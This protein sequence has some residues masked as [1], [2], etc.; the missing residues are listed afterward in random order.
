MKPF[1]T[2]AEESV[3]F[4][5]GKRAGRAARGRSG[6]GLVGRVRAGVVFANLFFRISYQPLKKAMGIEVARSYFS[7]RRNR[8]QCAF[9]REDCAHRCAKGRA[10]RKS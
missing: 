8:G 3:Q 5:T 2:F 6:D 4:V 1:G 7:P 9:A 10:G